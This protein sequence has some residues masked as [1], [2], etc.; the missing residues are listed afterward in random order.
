[1]AAR[2]STVHV[3]GAKPGVN[4]EPQ[5]AQEMGAKDSLETRDR[6]CS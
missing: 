2:S 4:G 6:V 3:R 5:R 1:M